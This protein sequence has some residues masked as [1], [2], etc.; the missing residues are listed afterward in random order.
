MARYIA[1]DRIIHPMQDCTENKVSLYIL[2]VIAMPMYKE[3]KGE[4]SITITLKK[5]L[6]VSRPR[7]NGIIK[8]QNMTK[9]VNSGIVK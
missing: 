1:D 5:P 7:L 8:A 9:Y 6:D 3:S 2:G 4:A